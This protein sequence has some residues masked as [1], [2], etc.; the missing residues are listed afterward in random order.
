MFPGG[1]FPPAYFPPG[2]W[3]GAAGVPA[4]VPVPGY[5]THGYWPAGYFPRAYWEGAPP[6]AALVPVPGTGR[7][8][9]SQMWRDNCF[10]DRTFNGS[11]TAPRKASPVGAGLVRRLIAMA[12]AEHEQR[13]LINE[14]EAFAR[15]RTVLKAR[16]LE[17]KL[18]FDRE[19]ERR[20][21]HSIYSVLVAEL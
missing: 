6:T 20:Q 5:F 19:L 11:V 2:Y 12:Q 7:M 16:Q 17:N 4:S 9:G 3:E 13:S 18:A 15:F 10:R 21:W 8:F 14:Q 1:Y